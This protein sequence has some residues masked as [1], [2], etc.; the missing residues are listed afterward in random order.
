MLF[1]TDKPLEEFFAIGL[2]LF[3]RTW[4][5]IH[6][7]STDIDIV[8]D[9]LREK[10]SKTLENSSATHSF[11]T[12]RKEL[13][14]ITYVEI[15]RRLNEER[16]KRDRQKEEL[17]AIKEL[18]K[19]LEPEMFDIVRQHR[20]NYLIEGT[21]FDKYTQKGIHILLLRI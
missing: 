1:D 13:S 14:K 10:L 8:C 9:F 4:H 17:P 3:N 18:K 20:L 12:F 16:Q 6:A 5:E 21:R 11:E 2:S 15:N 7:T 19:I